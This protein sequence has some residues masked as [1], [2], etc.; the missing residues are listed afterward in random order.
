MKCLRLIALGSFISALLPAQDAQ[1]LLRHT[2]KAMG[3][4][5]LKTFEYSD[6]GFFF[7]F[8]QAANPSSAWPKFYAKSGSVAKTGRWR[9][10]TLERCRSPRLSHSSGA[11]I[12]AR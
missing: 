4:E 10:D 7:W 12:L 5:N 2:A 11:T 1:A 6:S 9:F 8:G 3:A